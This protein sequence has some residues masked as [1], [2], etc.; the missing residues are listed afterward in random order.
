MQRPT[1]NELESFVVVAKHRS[2]RK[3]ADVLGVTR[4][5][6]SHTLASLEQRID[7]RL[8]NRTTRSVA[9]TDAGA[10][11]LQRLQPALHELDTALDTLADVRGAPSGTLRINAAKGA[12]RHL[13]QRVIPTFLA[14]YPE[15]VVDLVTEG[16][17]VDIVEDG[18]DAGVRLIEDVPQDM[19][20]VKLG[21]P[22]RFI[23]IAAPSYIEEH[24]RP[25]T[26]GALAEHRC[27]RQRLPSGK[28]YH[29]QFAKRGK[30]IDV[31]A[32]GA[33]S[34]DDNDLMVDAAVSGL[35]IAF[36]PETFAAAALA[37]GE[38]TTVLDDWCPPI[39]GLA[40]Y[41]PS[42]RHLRS[43]LRAFIATVRD[44]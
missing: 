20:M 34:L 17:F 18:F 40:L 12:A 23:A 41:Y 3:A 26:P 7:A 31:D 32:P 28:R 15:V 16:R 36:V 2:F 35:G 9:L 6:L 37:R 13:M 22:L 30:E 29:W 19:I 24:G 38:V 25:K 1:L 44:R 39:P 21:D 5:A 42:R 27:I 10:R 14:R 8:L 33:L 11:L 43:A 4:S